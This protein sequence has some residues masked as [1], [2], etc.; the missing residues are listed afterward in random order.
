MPW[1]CGVGVD[2][3]RWLPTVQQATQ[4]VDGVSLRLATRWTLLFVVG[5]VWFAGVA[6]ASS[7]RQELMAKMAAR[8]QVQVR[9]LAHARGVVAWWRNRT[10]VYRFELRWLP[11]DPLAVRWSE[12]RIVWLNREL[13]ETR[14][15]IRELR[16]IAL[17]PAHY[18]GWRCIAG[19]PGARPGGGP[20]ESGGDNGAVNGQYTGILQMH[21]D[22]GEGI[23]GNASAYPVEQVMAAAE[24]G[25]QHAAEQ[26]RAQSWLIQQWSQTIGPCWG[27]FE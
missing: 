25:W 26:G 24:R 27:F 20:G 7:S 22:W 16:V 15:T 3:G 5:A 12:R 9:A 21:P 11:P 8:E 14:S 1:C 17:R 13:G 6:S 10:R 23:S 2:T 18:D 19:Y 4:E